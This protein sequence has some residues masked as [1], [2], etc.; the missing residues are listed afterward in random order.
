FVGPEGEKYVRFCY[1]KRDEP[2]N[3]AMNQLRAWGKRR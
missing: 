2:L 1:A 3:R